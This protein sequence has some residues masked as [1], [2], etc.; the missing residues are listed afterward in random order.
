MRPTAA[1]ISQRVRIAGGPSVFADVPGGRPPRG[2]GEHDD[3]KREH[4]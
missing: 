1:R 4:R 3:T 2:D